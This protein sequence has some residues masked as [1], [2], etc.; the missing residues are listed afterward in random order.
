VCGHCSESSVLIL[1][2]VYNISYESVLTEV[3]CHNDFH[4]RS[5]MF[6]Q[7]VERPTELRSQLGTWS[8]TNGDVTFQPG[9]V[10]DSTVLQGIERNVQQCLLG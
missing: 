5:G 3:S 10:T 2:I 8:R 4:A 6:R 7:I 1:S 9:R